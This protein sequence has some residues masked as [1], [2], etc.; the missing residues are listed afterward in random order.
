MRLRRGLVG[1]GAALVAGWSAVASAWPPGSRAG[2]VAFAVSVALVLAGAAALRRLVSTEA[3]AAGNERLA[4]VGPRDEGLLRWL[5]PWLVLGVVVAIWEALGI[6]TGRHEPH[7]TLSALTLHY[8]SVRAGALAGWLWVGLC[9]GLART[10]TRAAA[11]GVPDAAA[12]S[13]LA[14]GPVAAAG[15]LGRAPVAELALLEG[16]SRAVG[17]G[18]WL[19][20]VVA[21]AV[22]ELVARRSA[23]KLADFV[24]LLAFVSRPFVPRVLEAAAWAYA[25]W[26]LFA[27]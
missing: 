19:G 2:E 5:G 6:A 4:S 20:V 11:S 21:A 8:R 3:A 13:G 14:A 16:R 7:L 26:H 1:L 22:I 27:H 10:A 9:F 12:P 25:G 18:F 15:H 17:V 24:A 23:G